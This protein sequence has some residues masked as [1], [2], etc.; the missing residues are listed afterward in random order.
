[1]EDPWVLF[2]LPSLWVMQPML[3]RI[4]STD[5]KCFLRRPIFNEWISWN[6]QDQKRV[7]LFGR[8]ILKTKLLGFTF[9]K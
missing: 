4:S 8:F 3:Q 9:W 5:S 7:F 6:T 1:L 2:I